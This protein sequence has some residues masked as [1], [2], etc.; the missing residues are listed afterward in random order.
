MDTWML[1]VQFN[2]KFIEL[3]I[4]LVKKKLLTKERKHNG[5]KLLGELSS[6][7]II[8]M[9]LSK[10]L[11]FCKIQIAARRPDR[12]LGPPSKLSS[13]YQGLFPP[14]KAA[15][16]WNWPQISNYCEVQESM[17][18]SIYPLPRT[19]SWRISLGVETTLLFLI[20][21]RVF[22]ICD[23]APVIWLWGSL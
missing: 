4:C 3:C 7:S 12:F 14:S 8:H 17:V 19:P 16:A 23:E 15:R 10:Y 13:G 1:V 9:K 11:Q 22:I 21:R 6:V 20:F 2:A 5:G 18:L